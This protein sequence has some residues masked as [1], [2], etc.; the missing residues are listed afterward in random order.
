MRLLQLA[1]TA[2]VIAVTAACASMSGYP[3]TF[4]AATEIDRATKALAE[5][6]TA[7]ADSLAADALAQARKTLDEAQTRDRQG[8]SDRA[9]ILARR[10]SIEA[11]YA[12]ALAERELA[13]RARAEAQKAMETVPPA[14][15]P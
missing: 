14:G 10:A 15:A 4:P 2:G 1:A 6:R 11:D 13:Q 5:A 9:A 3:K 8:E 12:Q 7:G